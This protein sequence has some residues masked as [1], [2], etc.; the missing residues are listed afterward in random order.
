MAKR[1]A[2]RRAHPVGFIVVTFHIYPENGNFV[3]VC[4]EL[5]VASCGDTVEEARKNIQE[6]TLLYL[7]T[8][9]EKGERERIF[10]KRD[11]AIHPAKPK[12]H[13]VRASLGEFVIPSAIMMPDEHEQFTPVI[14]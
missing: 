7:N 4:P 2:S 6:A 12:G 13:M 10:R 5:D 3:S 8:I 1:N 14:K 11:I 9:E